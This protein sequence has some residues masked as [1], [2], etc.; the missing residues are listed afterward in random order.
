MQAFAC[1]LRG[2][3]HETILN[4]ETA[5]QAKAD[6]YSRISEIGCSFT[7]IRVRR[8]GGPV[9]TDDLARTA[10]YREVPFVRA[11]MRIKVEEDFGSVVDSND[12]ANF[13]VLFETGRHKGLILN[14]HPTWR[15][16]YFNDDGTVLASFDDRG[17][18][19]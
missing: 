1:R 18:R 13:D 15:T 9:T 5:G 7:D 14:C 3:E 11:G 12:S 6:F 4:R 19:S 2:S 16:T 8:V 17:Q 10:K